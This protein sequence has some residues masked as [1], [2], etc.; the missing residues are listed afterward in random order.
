M[1]TDPQREAFRDRVKQA[2][3]EAGLTQKAFEQ[4]VGIKSGTLTRVFGG[5]KQLDVELLEAIA[6]GLDLAP[7]VLVS[8]TPWTS[9]LA[10]ADPEAS[11]DAAPVAEVSPELPEAEPADDGAEASAPQGAP[12]E[13]TAA[14][15]PE[16]AAAPEPEAAEEP[17]PAPGPGDAHTGRQRRE[18]SFYDYP[19]RAAVAVAGGAALVGAALFTLLRR[20]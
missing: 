8:G 9:L 14:P 2:L 20:R 19:I 11:E 3:G 6:G 1:A 5:K 15:E 16:A 12:D 18:R 4:Q 17:E 10:G 13:A 7:E